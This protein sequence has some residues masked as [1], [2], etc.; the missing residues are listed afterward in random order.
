MALATA[1]LD[2]TDEAAVLGLNPLAFPVTLTPK[3]NDADLAAMLEEQTLTDL[4]NALTG[5]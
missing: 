3:D 4:L 5:Q 1:I 2:Q